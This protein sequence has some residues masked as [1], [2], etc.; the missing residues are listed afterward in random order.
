MPGANTGNNVFGGGWDPMTSSRPGGNEPMWGQTPDNIEATPRGSQN[1]WAQAAGWATQ[2]GSNQGVKS[3]GANPND[4]FGYTG[5]SLLTPWTKE[6]NYTGPSAQGGGYSMPKFEFGD[7]G[8][9]FDSYGYMDKPKDIATPDAFKFANY[10]PAAVYNA[11][12]IS[13]PGQ[14]SSTYGMPGDFAGPGQFGYNGP[15]VPGA[16]NVGGFS[17]LPSAPGI[18][19]IDAFGKSG[20]ITGPSALQ[21]YTAP[22]QFSYSPMQTPDRFSAPSNFVAPNMIDD[23]GYQ[24]RLQRGLDAMT[25]TA[26]A[27]GTARGGDTLKA[28]G[29]YAQDSA[30]QEYQNTWNRAFQ[31]HNQDYSNLASAYQLDANT[32]M[33]ANN[34]QFGQ[35]LS[36]YSTNAQNQLAAFQA[37]QQARQA[38]D[39]MRIGV[40]TTNEANR[41]SAYNANA[42]ATNA[43]NANALSLYNSQAQ[44]QLNAYNANSATAF[45]NYD[46]ALASQNQGW[47][48][49]FN[50][51]NANAANSAQAYA[52]N[53]QRQAQGYGQQQQAFQMNADNAFRV[54]SANEA[55]RL[56]AAQF[57]EANRSNA[58]NLNYQTATGTYDRNTKNAIDVANMNFQNQL[59]AYNANSQ[60]A[61]NNANIGW[62]VASGTWDRNYQKALTGYQMQQQQ[63]AANA[64]ASASAAN[65]DYNRALQQYQMQYDIYRT[66]Q[67]DQ[68]NR[69]YQMAALGQNAAGMYNSAADAY[70]NNY[71]GAVYGGANA[72]AGAYVNNGAVWGNAMQGIGSAVGTGVMASS[73]WI[74]AAGRSPGGGMANPGMASAIPWN[75][76]SD[77]YAAAIPW[78]G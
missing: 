18:N 30:S 36:A 33:A 13:A 78:G 20:A 59:A 4:P 38:N 48:Q 22:Q 77:P 17:G 50:A 31:A 1:D 65:M 72:R 52:L 76:N 2:Q 8:Y 5:D 41:L 73:P 40:D 57:N 23:P 7:M 61:A 12:Q 44:N 14:F 55:N 45:G 34:Q 6:F 51:Y 66:N 16:A 63:A 9:S 64:A 74:G 19:T 15:Q 67:S 62:Q 43:N 24:I 70:G 11:S 42:Y 3:G 69:L 25:N 60:T 10:D 53:L 75:G 47:Q 35:A 27:K 32:A 71:A 58:Y 46:R 26:L 29:D 49:A 39:A 56:A 21:T 68:F 54:Q 37:N 28:M